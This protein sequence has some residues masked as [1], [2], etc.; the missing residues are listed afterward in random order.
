MLRQNTGYGKKTARM[1]ASL[2]IAGLL[3][4]SLAACKEESEIT[5]GPTAVPEQPIHEEPLD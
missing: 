1:L 5:P 3:I 2:A 4:F